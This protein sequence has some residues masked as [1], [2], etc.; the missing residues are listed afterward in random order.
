MI[1]IG[2]LPQLVGSVFDEDNVSEVFFL[3]SVPVPRPKSPG[4]PKRRSVEMAKLMPMMSFNWRD[5]KMKD[6][7]IDGS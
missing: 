2:D 1:H 5:E 6:I 7:E 4:R 3:T